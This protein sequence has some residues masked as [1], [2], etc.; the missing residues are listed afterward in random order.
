VTNWKEG[1]ET[2]D[3]AGT[4][5]QC[6]IETGD[7]TIP[8]PVEVRKDLRSMTVGAFSDVGLEVAL[9]I[10]REYGEPILAF[11]EESSP[12]FVGLTAVPTA[13]DLARMLKLRS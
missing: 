9:S 12:D 3:P 8:V 13:Q 7:G 4:L 6:E 10:Q 1:V 2:V 11:S 5:F